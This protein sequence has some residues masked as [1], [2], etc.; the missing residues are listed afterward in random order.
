MCQYE[1]HSKRRREFDET[2]CHETHFAKEFFRF[3]AHCHETFFAKDFLNHQNHQK[4]F[5]CHLERRL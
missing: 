4:Y 1:R 5:Y 2:R 3:K